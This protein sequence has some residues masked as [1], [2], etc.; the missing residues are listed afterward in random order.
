MNIEL[1]TKAKVA[2]IGAGP[3][4]LSCAQTLLD[5]GY[6]VDIFEVNSKAGGLSR[7]I[8]VMGQLVDL[9]PHYFRTQVPQVQQYW[10]QCTQGIAMHK[11]ERVSHILYQG[12]LFSYPLKGFEALF[13]LG[14][15]ESVLCVLSYLRSVV[16]PHKGNTFEAWVSNAFGY[17]LY[18]IF[19]KTYSEKLWG[20]KCSQLSD[21][22]AKERIK[23]LNL[24]KAIKNALVPDKTGH[25]VR[26]LKAEFIYPKMGIGQVYDQALEQVIKSGGRCFFNHQVDEIV[27]NNNKVTGISVSKVEPHQ[28]NES[29]NAHF[30]KVGDSEFLEYDYVVSSGIFTDLVPTIKC[31]PLE[32]RELSSKLKFRNT[33]LVYLKVDESAGAN[34]KDNWLYIH[35]PEVLSGRMCDY[36]NWSKD[37]QLGQK[38]HIVCFEYWAQE[39]DALWQKDNEALIEQAKADAI[40]SGIFKAGSIKEGF[41]HRLYK[42]Y[43][44]YVDDYAQVMKSISNEL[45]KIAGLYFIGRNGSFKYN[46]MDHSIHMGI[47]AAHKIANKYHGSL[48]DLNFDGS[49]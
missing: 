5:L 30:T 28:D 15:F 3:A 27:V 10:D 47:L 7:T 8:E 33:I 40:A 2:V 19:F 39:S 17:R 43:P 48:W 49:L 11:V 37:M 21:Q 20:V 26:S 29:S 46:N 4:G 25:K 42:S 18:S 13:K 22:F 44:M 35:S 34:L 41:V 45:D 6:Q 14:F 23:T 24:S 38:E 12:K 1:K 9:G 16:L 36:A 32:T 31:L